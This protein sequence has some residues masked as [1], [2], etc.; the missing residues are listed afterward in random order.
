MAMISKTRLKRPLALVAAASATATA[1]LLLGGCSVEW[2]NLQPARE[3]A[4]QAKPPG[5]VY[6]GWRVYQDKCAQCH[7]AEPL[8]TS[9]APNLVIRLRDIGPQRFAS[10]VLTRYDFSLPGMPPRSDAP[11]PDALIDEVVARKAG[12]I[13][14]PAWQGEPR[15]NAHIM[16]LYAYLSARAQGTQGPGRPAP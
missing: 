13:A 2:M 4:E 1:A 9:R 8:G 6:A 12:D 10:L 3:L 5:E 14:M 7:G 11:I 15:V 16:D